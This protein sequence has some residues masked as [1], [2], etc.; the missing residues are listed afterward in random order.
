M[1]GM[2]PICS[3]SMLSD[4][5]KK[6]L[7]IIWA[8]PFGGAERQVVTI[9]SSLQSDGYD[10]EVVCLTEGGP[11]AD[12]LTAKN[13]PV[14]ILHKK[15]G[16]DIKML[17]RLTSLIKKIKPDVVHTHI[18]TSNFWGRLAAFFAGRIPCV[19]HEHSTATLDNNKRLFFDKRLLWISDKIIAVSKD[20]YNRFLN[21]AK[22]PK[23]KL[24]TIYNGIP[25]EENDVEFSPKELKKSIGAEKDDL[26]IG[27]VSLVEPRKD[28]K[29]FLKSA[30]EILKTKPNAIF[31]VAG[32]GPML[33]EIKEFAD[34][35]GISKKVSFLGWRDDIR[36]L[37][38][39][40]DV[41]VSSSTTE[42]ISIAL[43]EAM[44]SKTPAVVTPVGGNIELVKD[45]ETGLLANVGDGPD[46]NPKILAE[47]II[48]ALEHPK[49]R[50]TI[51]DNANKMVREK[52][53]HKAMMEKIK[54]IY[55]KVSS[56]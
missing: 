56:K 14:H 15:A 3:E 51:V 8:L 33:L 34:T 30:V 48:W 27:I 47:K 35:L 52:F 39:I 10:V 9:A 40:L 50:N 7:H 19:V 36:P 6:I 46:R 29:L 16:L 26:L 11:L 2:L 38:S 32:D 4:M 49:E 13:I 53:S 20:I 24:T 18:F 17:F 55:D 21:E 37:I 54:Q 42:G 43:L 23:D 5:N 31:I 45:M 22:Y 12:E 28:H 41:Y 25:F 1:V 44:Y